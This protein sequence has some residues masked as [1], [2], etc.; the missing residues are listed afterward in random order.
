MVSSQWGAPSAFKKGFDLKDVE[1]GKYGTHIDIWEWPALVHQKSLDLGTEGLMPLE[2]RFLHYPEASEGYVGCA[3]GSTVWRFFKDEDGSWSVEKVI[4]I[5]PKKVKG[6]ILEDMPAVITDILISLDDRYLY[7]VCWIHGDIRQYDITDTR[8][9]KL[10]GQVFTGGS[11]YKGGPVTVLHDEELKEQ[12]ERCVI[13]NKPVEGAGQM[14]QLSLD[15]KRLYATTSLYSAWDKQFYPE[16]IKK[17]AMMLRVNVDNIL[18]GLCIDRDFL[19]DFGEEPDGPVLAHEMRFP[20]G[21][22]TSDIWL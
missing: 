19:V 12:P 13:K 4:T 7:I 3:L 5:P 14:L 8:H 17:G 1:D 16:L 20:G 15:G 21:D 22:S 18:G 10:V 11:I 9:P 2:V 6:W